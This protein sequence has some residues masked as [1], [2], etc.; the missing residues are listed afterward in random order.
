VTA[1]AAEGTATS[2]VDR[3]LGWL[4][5]PALADLSAQLRS[6]TSLSHDERE[7]VTTGVADALREAVWARVNRV[8]VLELNG[9]RLEGRLTGADPH[10]RWQEWVDQLAIR[11]GWQALADPYPV[12]LPRLRTIVAN[13]CAAGAVLAARFDRD[14]T[15]LA[16]I[17]GTALG[18]LRETRFGAGDSHHGGH[19]V[20]LLRCDAATVVYKPRSLLVDA[21]LAELVARLLPEEPAATRIRV[22]QV[23]H[24]HDRA[25]GY[26]W[27][28]HVA[29]RSCD[30]EAQLRAFYR[31]LGHWLAV[32]RLVGGSDLH[33][34]NL[35]ACGPVPV[36]VDCETLF[37]PPRASSRSGYGIAVDRAA[38]LLGQSV[39]RTGLLPGR[40]A[41][42]GGRGIDMSG[43][44]ALPGQ[45]PPVPVPTIAG[46]GTDEARVTFVT[47]PPSA[48]TANHPTARPDLGRYWPQVVDGFTGLSADLRA[49]DRV[50]QLA[51][52]L[53]P[54]RHCPVRVVLRDTAVYSELSWMLWHPSSLHRSE[55]ARQ[56]ATDLLL[57]HARH[58]PGAP[59]DP[60]VVDAEI[61]AL[62][63]GDIPAFVT[64]PATG[65]MT[66][67]AGVRWGARG[68]LV[69][70]ALERWRRVDPDLD[71][72]VVEATLMAAYLN[73]G[74]EQ[75][76]RP[77]GGT[78]A[79]S[80]LDLDRRRRTQAAR[81]VRDL[82]N[83]AVRGEDATATWVAPTLDRTGW[84]V[85]ALTNDL[86]GGTVGVAVLLA[87]YQREVGRGRADEVVGADELLEAVLHTVRLA[88][89]QQRHDLAA[90]AADGIRVRPEPPGAY[91]GIG[92]RI[93]GWLL[94]HR[95]G[96]VTAAE[97]QRRGEELAAMLPGAVEADDQQDLLSGA[98]GAVVPL[99]R[100]AEHPA[101]SRW[102]AFA[103]R[104]ADRL[105]D[106]AL[107]LDDGARWPVPSFPDGIGGLSH[108]AAGIGWALARLAAATG[109]TDLRDLAR[110]AFAYQDTLFDR[111]RGG[112]RDARTPE[113][114]LTATWCHGAV[115]VGLCA[116]DLLTFDLDGDRQL[117]TLL[118]A[119]IATWP[120]GFD[121]THTLCHGDTSAWELLDR[122]TAAGIAAGHPHP[123]EIVARVVSDLEDRGP[124]VGTARE[125]F[126]PGLLPGLAGVAYQLLRMHPDSEL[127]SVLLPDPGPL[128]VGPAG[129]LDE[130]HRAELLH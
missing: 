27:A 109:D 39:L 44:G 26:G 29:H 62:A 63:A 61:S 50:G 30:G 12:L 54:F 93:W 23:W 32:M 45:Q 13:R 20:A 36:V 51:P 112:W 64:T 98:A 28:E 85:R 110:A 106:R 126:L 37:T 17:A 88:D 117:D 84:S 68:D 97:A 80:D 123:E 103:R 33:A 102:V 95:C 90:A 74:W 119:A 79:V 114:H 24:R 130:A 107:L 58:R 11:A 67:P 52:L 43:V 101:G 75:R 99:L 115:G 69:A 120:R 41:A 128:L 8:V 104:I 66:G 19:T 91:L 3:M 2:D 87:A 108:G 111:R 21:A 16:R 94:L 96:A 92:S 22:P 59:D 25:G 78:V 5:Q 53:E 1:E 116:A 118:R 47:T 18:P 82:A 72:R 15:S 77:T 129:V 57:R 35:V 46:R 86:Y 14:R 34:E 122:A 89:D 124:V 56:R 55:P 73:D 121:L 76:R 113:G 49:R 70:S 105:R 38:A 7:A 6:T 65:A 42:L 71:R 125:V 83:H 100:L 10:A 9:A 40:G 31:G 48:P 127:P 4:V 60:T 81:I